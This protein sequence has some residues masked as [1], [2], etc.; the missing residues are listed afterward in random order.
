MRTTLLLTLLVCVQ[1]YECAVLTDGE[2]KE[3]KMFQGRVKLLQRLLRVHCS[4]SPELLRPTTKFANTLAGERVF[5]SQLSAQ[6]GYCKLSQQI[7]LMSKPS[8]CLD[9]TDL[10][11][12]WRRDHN[13]GMNKPGGP[14]SLLN[15]TCDLRQSLQWFRFAGEAGDRMLSSA[16]KS[17]SCGTK[18]PYW[19]DAEMPTEVGVKEE[20]EAFGVQGSFSKA[21]MVKLEVMRCSKGEHDY[22]YKYIGKYYD[23]CAEAFCGMK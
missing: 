15:Q 6:L 16:P 4:S 21:Y 1:L 19:T 12:S 5:Y 10:T 18:L 17:N 8:E 2:E 11:E 20:I 9:A 3:L 14:N 7:S 23:E 13:G 22:I